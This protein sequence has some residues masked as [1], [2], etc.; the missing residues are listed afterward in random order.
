VNIVFLILRT[1]AP[2]YCFFK[3][4]NIVFLILLC[5]YRTVAPEYCFFKALNIV[6]FI[7]LCRYR[8]GKERLRSSLHSAPIIDTRVLLQN[9]H[10]P[11]DTS[12]V[13]L[14]ET[15]NYFVFEAGF[16]MLLPKGVPAAQAKMKYAQPKNAE[17]QG[18]SSDEDDDGDED[19]D[20][21]GVDG[22]GDGGEEQEEDC[23][24]TNAE[25][26]D[27]SQDGGG[28]G[29]IKKDSIAADDDEEL[30]MKKPLI[31]VSKEAFRGVQ[32][33]NKAQAQDFV[34]VDGNCKDVGFKKAYYM[35]VV[36]P[37][38]QHRYIIWGGYI[39]MDQLNLGIS[40]KFRI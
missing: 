2:E 5:R 22:D 14:D 25:D 16:E 23:E 36:D 15:G 17:K 1:V 35:R 19:D 9:V 6:F 4:L 11:A 13:R 33:E 26:K 24:T 7:L 12:T 28:G 31:L 32:G 40:G 29:G 39:S 20:D 27:G 3:A 34:L 18:N 8:T 30:V 21:E 10:M 38:L 37:D